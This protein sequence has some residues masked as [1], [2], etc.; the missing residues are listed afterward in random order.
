MNETHVSGITYEGGFRTDTAAGMV[1]R[2]GLIMIYCKPS[3]PQW[4]YA[5]LSMQQN[6]QKNKPCPQYQI[7]CWLSFSDS[8]ELGLTISTFPAHETASGDELEQLKC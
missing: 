4:D 6:L 8:W 1:L 2:W 5:R 3:S 7:L